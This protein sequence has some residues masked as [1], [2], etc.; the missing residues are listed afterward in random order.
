LLER[1]LTELQAHP[2]ASL[3]WGNQRFWREEADGSWTDTGRNIWQDRPEDALPELFEWPDPRHMWQALHSVGSMVARS[4]AVQGSM[5]P[6]STDFAATE[7]YRERMYP[8]PILFV[9]ERLG[10][11][12][13]TRGTSRSADPALSTMAQALLAGSLYTSTN[14]S[15]DELREAWVRASNE[16]GPRASHVL[17]YS[18]LFFPDCRRLL[19]FAGLSDWLWFLAYSVRRPGR[20]LRTVRLHQERQDEKEFLMHHT[21]KRAEESKRRKTTRA[22]D[23]AAVAR[24]G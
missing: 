10:N 17:F 13:L 20:L 19:R 22:G 11:F 4:A 16:G 7:A 9:P 5:V 12:A 6:L 3:A 1:L 14:P 18:A 23:P 8:F 2:E 15:D 21:R 24:E